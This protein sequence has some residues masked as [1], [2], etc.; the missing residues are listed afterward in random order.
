MKIILL[1]GLL[2][3]FIGRINAQFILSDDEERTT[4][5][6][7]PSSLSL[8]TDETLSLSINNLADSRSRL[9]PFLWGV[10]YKGGSADDDSFL[11][12]DGDF[13]ISSELSAFVGFSFRMDKGR[14]VL[15]E[16][17]KKQKEADPFIDLAE[18]Y[19]TI[20]DSFIKSVV[21]DNEKTKLFNFRFLNTTSVKKKISDKYTHFN[22]ENANSFLSEPQIAFNTI[23]E[24][25][26]KY[27]NNFGAYREDL[28]V[29]LGLNLKQTEINKI[30]KDFLVKVGDVDFTKN[31]AAQEVY[32]L[33]MAIELPLYENKTKLNTLASYFEIDVKNKV[34]TNIT[35]YQEMKIIQTKELNDYEYFDFF[36][37][38]GFTY[39][40]VDMIKKDFYNKVVKKKIE[41]ANNRK[42]NSD[43]NTQR[44]LKIQKLEQSSGGIIRGTV[45]LRS[46]L[47]GSEFSR[48][49]TVF[50]SLM[51]VDSLV[52]KN[53]KFKG[54]SY[55]FGYNI[56]F[57]GKHIIGIS[58]MYDRSNNFND[59]TESNYSVTHIDTISGNRYH[60]EQ[61][62]SAYSGNY[63]DQRRQVFS[64]DY[65]YLI[66]LKTSEEGASL[67]TINP[68]F[69][70]YWNNSEYLAN[71][72]TV[73]LGINFYKKSDKFLFG[74]FIQKNDMFDNNTKENEK[75]EDTINSGIRIAY[76]FNKLSSFIN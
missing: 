72:S 39:D 36:L 41:N 9:T 6:N 3:L 46:G 20:Y 75:F 24:V 19:N 47:F 64:I 49:D 50:S 1:V 55:E 69:R 28:S 62:K 13:V 35:S 43:S 63:I 33:F 27:A 52:F 21:W 51:T 7:T 31:E 10:N 71:E 15:M 48:I 66:K 30:R 4:F 68:Y 37:G 61:V 16:M 23:N 45:F 54:L 76:S 11:F 73:G 34:A 5:L 58:F 65:A 12:K 59:L 44:I 53:E 18:D 67:L 32:E 60:S 57:S 40:E 29:N 38:V 17:I 26:Y 70:H 8:S 56:S 74:F 2:F 25:D 14:K 42:L 22:K